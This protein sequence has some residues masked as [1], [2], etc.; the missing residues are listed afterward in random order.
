MGNYQRSG[1]NFSPYYLNS[2]KLAG[3]EKLDAGYRLI[4]FTGLFDPGDDEDYER[5]VRLLCNMITGDPQVKL[6]VEPVWA[7]NRQFLA[8]VGA[9]ERL[10]ELVIPQEKT[11]TPEVI[12]LSLEEQIR[13]LRFQ[14]GSGIETLLAK[15]AL[16]WAIDQALGSFASGWW[17]YGRRFIS[18]VPDEVSSNDDVLVHPAFYVNVVPGRNAWLEM[19]I[20]PSV[21][22]VERRSTYEK[23]GAL[24]PDRIKGKRHLYKNGRD[25]YK[26][27]ALGVGG[28]ADKE[29][30]EDPDTGET[31]SIYQRLI[32]R[33][34]KCGIAEIANLCPQALTI[35]YKTAGQKYRR[36]ASD[37]L[38]EMPGV[39]STDEGEDAPHEESILEA[40][41]RGQKTVDVIEEVCSRLT[42][43]GKKLTPSTSL[44]PL[45]KDEIAVF[46]PPA[47]RFAG[48]QIVR[49][50]LDEAGRDRFSALRGIG[51]AESTPFT[52]DQHLIISEG[53]P[54]VVRK[55]FRQRFG[56]ALQ[57]LYG[58]AW[59]HKLIKFDDRFART[60]RE[61]ARAIEKEV[62]NRRGYGLLVLPVMKNQHQQSRLHHYLKRSLWGQKL[63]TQCASQEQILS[64]YQREV[65]NG[66][67]RWFVRQRQQGF[68][69]SYLRYLALG[70]LMVNKKWLWKLAEG[71]LRNQVHVGIDV[72]KGVAVFTFIYGD[73][74]LI[75]FYVCDRAK[76][77]EKLSADQVQQVLVE[78]LGP[79]LAQLGIEPESIVFH[80]DGKIYDSELLGIRRAIMQLKQLRS[81]PEKLNYGVV[82]I[83]KT[84]VTKPRLYRRLNGRFANPNM[85]LL[86]RFGQREGA[87]ATTGYPMLKRGTAQPLYLEVVEGNI[88][89]LD[90]AHDIYALSHLAFAS[91]GSC[92]SLPFTIALADHILRESHP[93]KDDSLWEEEE[94]V[95]VRRSNS[96]QMTLYFEKGGMAS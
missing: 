49:T 5:K 61:K 55:D 82:E 24:I 27:D 77:P 14:E 30:M 94:E 20:D 15:R 76:R 68:Y 53:M 84:S 43:F 6:P 1:Q 23:Y 56:V 40:S 62:I 21:C 86:A 74:D 41:V 85:G 31:I 50:R 90:I 2:F 51:P 64:F 47:L 46:D 29:M 95:Q 78:N 59:E 44:R 12:T 4:S 65:K 80:R 11:L 73:A 8:V 7:G 92:M 32:N 87:L 72:Y 17:R 37:L 13:S 3:L 25:W 35:A 22:Y 18:R 52:G 57:D 63:Q 67:E 38:F 96:P 34:G 9:R 88:D 39:E 16:N 33:W 10:S 71:S 45:R 28:P 60:L 54:E 48:D 93:G 91:P 89:L 69:R 70:Y 79:D 36:A 75:T 26:I 83:R 81:V 58:K 19:I 66:E 42:L